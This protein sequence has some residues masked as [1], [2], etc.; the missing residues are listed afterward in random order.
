MTISLG[1]EILLLSAVG[2]LG[3][4]I[5]LWLLER[6]N[7]RLLVVHFSSRTR[8]WG[9]P[10]FFIS[11]AVVVT[12]SFDL[13]PPWGAENRSTTLLAAIWGILLLA[14]YG[15][16]KMHPSRPPPTPSEAGG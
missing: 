10:T 11:V 16:L 15:W 5:V 7:P 14:T 2:A 12:I 4:G 13:P 8:R 1:L 6:R 9:A 3:A